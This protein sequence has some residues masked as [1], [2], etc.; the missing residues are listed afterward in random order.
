MVDAVCG[1]GKKAHPK[2]SRCP[3]GMKDTPPFGNLV[4]VKAYRCCLWA[5]AA[6][7]VGFP[8]ANAPFLARQAVLAR[9][10]S[11]LR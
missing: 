8:G 11:K 5:G 6:S 7:G 1:F 10:K 4:M 9:S 3:T 2:S